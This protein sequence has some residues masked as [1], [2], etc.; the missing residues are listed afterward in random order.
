M[1][2]QQTLLAQQNGESAP[3]IVD[4]MW[5]DLSIRPQLVD[6]FNGM[7]RPED[8]ARVD[9]IS[10]VD[11]LDD[12]EGARK[13][14]IFKSVVD[15]E[16]LLPRLGDKFDIIGYNLEHGPSNRPDEQA[17]PVGSV[18]RMRALADQYGKE[19]ALGPDRGFA[20]SDGAAMAPYVDIFILQVQRVQEEPATVRSFVEPLAAQFRAANP[21]VEISVQIR[22]EGDVVALRDL[23][24][25]MAGTLDG[26]SILTSPETVDVAA[27]LLDVL[28][29]DDDGT[30]APGSGVTDP[31]GAARVQ[32][33][34][35]AASATD[36][37]TVIGSEGPSSDRVETATPSQTPI[38]PPFP[39]ESRADDRSWF[40][41]GSLL[42]IGILGGGLMIAS[43]IYA[44]Q[45]MGRG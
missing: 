1:F 2:H 43:L 14:V 20:L 16:A 28:R 22:T 15:A 13:L 34:P 41:A 17:D 37:S 31:A 19:L 8:I 3:E 9:H 30:L 36:G 24:A 39:Q 44:Y 4:E 26:I 7:A 11:V 12:V 27:E 42:T 5:I 23:M 35:T 38:A 25:S 32:A 10:M 21:D 40:I 33:Q 45:N 18:I 29:P 6:Q